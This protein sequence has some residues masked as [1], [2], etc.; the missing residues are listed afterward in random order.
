MNGK[1][2]FFADLRTYLRKR[3]TKANVIALSGSFLDDVERAFCENDGL[4]LIRATS[5]PLFSLERKRGGKPSG[6]GKEHDTLSFERVC[7]KLL[8]NRINKDKSF[9]AVSTLLGEKAIEEGV[10]SG[11]FEARLLRG[12]DILSAYRE[13]RSCLSDPKT[14]RISPGLLQFLANPTLGVLALFDGEVDGGTKAV[15][16]ALVWEVFEGQGIGPGRKFLDSIY[17]EGSVLYRDVLRELARGY[18]Y[19]VK[20]SDSALA[21]WPLLQGEEPLSVEFSI[22]VMDFGFGTT[23][24][25]P[26]PW[27]DSMDWSSFET[28]LEKASFEQ[29]F[30]GMHPALRVG[31]A[32]DES[33]PNSVEEAWAT[34][35][36]MAKRGVSPQI[37]TSTLRLSV[38]HTPAP[39]ERGECEMQHTLWP[40]PLVEAMALELGKGIMNNV[41]SHCHPR[42]HDIL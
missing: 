18:G 16:R 32:Q 11:R 7:R 42:I 19:R 22:F 39:L 3:A 30:L 27:L 35:F 34:L 26:I 24:P 5:P 9:Q 13:V 2:A 29:A 6:Q 23:L 33:F 28:Y 37:T 1:Q 12:L 4:T 15:A 17:A 38:L 10:S 8:G 41:F 31:E 25:L 36:P 20:Y 40:A 14:D 21:G